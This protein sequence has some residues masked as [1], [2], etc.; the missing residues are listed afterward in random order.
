MKTSNFEDESRL[1]DVYTSVD[2]LIGGEREEREKQIC[3]VEKDKN[4]RCRPDTIQLICRHA[5]PSWHFQHFLSLSLSA[6]YLGIFSLDKEHN[7]GIMPLSFSSRFKVSFAVLCFP[8][9]MS[10]NCVVIEPSALLVRTS[11]ADERTACSS[12]RSF[13][14]RISGRSACARIAINESVSPLH[15]TFTTHFCFVRG[16]HTDSE[17]IYQS[18]F[19]T[20]TCYD[21][22]PKSGKVLML[23]ARLSIRKAFF[24]LVFNSVRAALVWHAPSLSNIAV[25]TISDFVNMLIAAYDSKWVRTRVCAR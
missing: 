17:E 4:Q 18:F 22:M 16:T 5:D 8:A 10:D 20:H 15:S 12:H 9:I 25:I 21:C 11:P 14:I 23:D 6:S 19:R 2:G 3:C 13:S 24:A 7:Q 1:S